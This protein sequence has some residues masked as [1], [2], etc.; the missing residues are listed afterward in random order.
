MRHEQHCRAV[1]VRVAIPL[2]RQIA[3][4]ADDVRIR[5]DTIPID[6]ESSADSALDR[7]GV[8]WRAVIRLDF[9]RCD[10]NEALLDFTVRLLR[11][12]R[13]RNRDRNGSGWN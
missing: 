4:I 7:A 8:P 1:F 3:T 6:H 9:R 13:D 2:D 12:D 10:A 11:S 5:H